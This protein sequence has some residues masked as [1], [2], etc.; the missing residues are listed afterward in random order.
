MTTLAVCKSNQHGQIL[1]PSRIRKKYGIRPQQEFKISQYK[2]GLYIEP[3]EEEIFDWS[4]TIIDYLPKAKKKSTNESFN[5]F[6][7]SDGNNES[8][9]EDMDE[10]LYS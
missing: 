4:H 5:N 6:S 8:I 3:I 9:I 1:I 10:I 7:F 2:K